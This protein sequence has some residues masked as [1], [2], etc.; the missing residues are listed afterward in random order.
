M[1]DAS[2]SST[3]PEARNV[4]EDTQ[5]PAET[6]ETDPAD[7]AGDKACWAYLVCPECGAVESEGHRPGCNLAPD[8]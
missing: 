6:V 5:A 2:T 1:H 7:E 8:E 3:P 4:A